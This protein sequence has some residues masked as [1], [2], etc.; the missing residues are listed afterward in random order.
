MV[1]MSINKLSFGSFSAMPLGPKTAC[2][3]ASPFGSIAIAK[4]ASA[5]ASAAEI[6]ISPPFS[7]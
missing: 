1:D 4:L 3:T 6:A 2:F 5:D 7:T